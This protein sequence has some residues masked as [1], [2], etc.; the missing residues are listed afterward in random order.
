MQLFC[1][2]MLLFPVQPAVDG[3][4]NAQVQASAEALLGNP[5]H[6]GSDGRAGKVEMRR[7]NIIQLR[8][9]A[10]KN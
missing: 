7:F 5:D 8:S 2:K 6:L 3:D 9:I 10:V 1:F 4:P